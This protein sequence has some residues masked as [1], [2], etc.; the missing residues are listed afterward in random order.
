MSA[1]KTFPAISN[2][3]LITRTFHFIVHFAIGKT[4]PEEIWPWPSNAELQDICDN[5]IEAESQRNRHIRLNEFQSIFRHRQ[6]NQE[7]GARYAK[8]KRP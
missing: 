3:M 4:S 8:D 2:D 6:M 7:N 5:P 1:G